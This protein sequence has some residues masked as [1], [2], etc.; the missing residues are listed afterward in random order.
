LIK[1]KR[2]KNLVEFSAYFIESFFDVVPVYVG[3]EVVYE[4]SS[5]WPVVVVVA[6][7]P[8]V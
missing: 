8:D 2:R 4:A 6:V 5:V 7:F 3:E 1:K